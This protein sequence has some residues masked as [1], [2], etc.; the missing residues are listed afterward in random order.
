MLAEIVRNQKSQKAGTVDPGQCGAFLFRDNARR[1]EE[2]C[3]QMPHAAI[4][5][6][7]SAL[8]LAL[9]APAFARGPWHAD[10]SNTP[11]WQ[12]MTPEERLEHQWIV[13]SFTSYDDCLAYQVTHHRL[14]EDRAKQRDVALPGEGRD[15]CAHL[16]PAPVAPAHDSD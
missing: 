5:I 13:R 1:H 4:R 10:G 14:M 9:L 2:P 11:G 15:F 16:K 3:T 7:I 12:L 6:V 8:S